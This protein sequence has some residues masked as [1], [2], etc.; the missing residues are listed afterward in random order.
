MWED[1]PPREE[2]DMRSMGS[3]KEEGIAIEQGKSFSSIASGSSNSIP[4]HHSCGL[5]TYD[6]CSGS[7]GLVASRTMSLF[8]T[9]VQVVILWTHGYGLLDVKGKLSLQLE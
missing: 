3:D 7:L 6:T 5:W 8:Y 2:K 4:Y 1:S 9:D